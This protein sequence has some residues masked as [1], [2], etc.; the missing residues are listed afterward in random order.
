[1]ERSTRTLLENLV[2]YAGLFPPASLA[3]KDAAHSFAEHRRCEQSWMLARFICPASRLSEL[4]EHIDVLAAASALVDSAVSKTCNV[5]GSMPW[6][7][8]KNLYVQAW[9]RDCKGCTT[10][11]SDG[12]RMGI[13]LGKEDAVEN[14]SAAKD[15]P[16]AAC[17]IDP[18][19]GR[20][21][22]S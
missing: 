5:D 6:D 8:F 3:M 13:L 11:N 14:D 9:E 2:D 17:F 1:M 4:G 19:T 18:E 12:K 20:R 15:E 22:C 7:D 16:E 10:F 21:E